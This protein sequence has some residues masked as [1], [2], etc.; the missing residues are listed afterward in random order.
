MHGHACCSDSLLISVYNTCVLVSENEFLSH[1]VVRDG[2]A[3]HVQLK[4]RITSDLRSHSGAEKLFF[5]CQSSCLTSLPQ[6]FAATSF[7]ITP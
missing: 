1:G 6:I 3:V 7:M 5:G 4:D 2:T